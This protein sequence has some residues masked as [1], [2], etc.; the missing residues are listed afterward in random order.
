MKPGHSQHLCAIVTLHFITK[1][2]EIVQLCMGGFYCSEIDWSRRNETI[3]CGIK[4][5][6]RKKE[7]QCK[8]SAVNRIQWLYLNLTM[9]HI[10]V[11]MNILTENLSLQYTSM[12]SGF[13][14]PIGWWHDVEHRS[15][16]SWSLP[17]GQSQVLGEFASRETTSPGWWPPEDFLHSGCGSRSYWHRRSDMAPGLWPWDPGGRERE[18][19]SFNQPESRWLRGFSSLC[20]L[21]KATGWQK[22]KK[23]TERGK[24]KEIKGNTI[25]S[26][27]AEVQPDEAS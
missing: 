22:D 6:N 12:V 8:T 24:I 9:S 21:I 25:L 4:I 14:L 18:R 27:A 17:G 3:V 10:A 23:K 7:N 20:S 13:L 15:I 2:S 11:V 26:R 5:F 16:P 19:I 1:P